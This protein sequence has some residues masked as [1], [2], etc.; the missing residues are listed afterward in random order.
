MNLHDIVVDEDL[1]YAIIIVKQKYHI[2]DVQSLFPNSLITEFDLAY[3]GLCAID[4]KT[5]K[6]KAAISGD[7]TFIDLDQWWEYL[8]DLRS[9]RMFYY[10]LIDQEFLKY[11][12]DGVF[13]GTYINSLNIVEGSH[14]SP[15]FKNQKLILLNAKL[16]DTT[17]LMKWDIDSSKE[18]QEMNNNINES[19]VEIIWK[20]PSYRSP[21]IIREEWGHRWEFINDPFYGTSNAHDVNI[22]NLPT[23]HVLMMDNGVDHR[24]S[25]VPGDDFACPMTRYV[26]YKIDTD[27]NGRTGFH[28]IT[29]IF[30]F[31]KIEDYPDFIYLENEPPFIE[32]NCQEFWEDYNFQEY[33]GSFRKL[34][35]GDYVMTYY[36]PSLVSMEVSK[37]TPRMLRVNSDG[38][39]VNSWYTVTDLSA[40]I[41]VSDFSSSYRINPINT[42]TFRNG[43]YVKTTPRTYA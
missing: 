7:G 5:G 22:F 29:L 28:R 35:D 41:P 32:R 13:D 27:F 20:L 6:E 2:R 37:M 18:L 1:E 14:F 9:S 16:Q 42:H 38:E 31:P 12:D 11:N 39:I 21:R 24:V 10:D 17:Y 34:E 25:N 40:D 15:K 36:P 26:E 23:G 33:I 19:S 8:D 4:L 30:S 43:A 3:D